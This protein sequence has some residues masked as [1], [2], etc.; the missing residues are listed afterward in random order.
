MLRQRIRKFVPASLRPHLGALR[1]RVVAHPLRVRAQRKR[2]LRDPSLTARQR[3]LLDR[4]SDR[5]HFRDGMYS[6]DGESYFRAGLSAVECL[7]EALAR[8]APPEIRRF[9][10]LPCGYG[11]ELRFFV[12]RFPGAAFTACDIQPG[13]VD[14]CAREFGARPAHSRISFAELSFAEH[15]DLVWCGS[16]V[17][18]LDAG[19]TFELLRLFARHLAPGGVAVFTTYGDYVAQRMRDE[20]ATYDLPAPSAAAIADSYART[21]HG[22]HDYPRG[23]G[24]FDFHPEGRGYG[25]SVTSPAWVREQARR[26]GYLEE[27]YFKE[28]GWWNHQDVFAFARRA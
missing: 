23:Q 1:R 22:Y 13:A 19:A 26:A 9:L 28:R 12:L 6:G 18:H 3:E 17:T 21:G 5:I 11:R 15:F 7:D 4:V 8:H 20:G 14:F 25:V 27:V 2:L 10:D 24:Y 16:L